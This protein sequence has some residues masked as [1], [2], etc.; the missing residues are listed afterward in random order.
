MQRV[1]RIPAPTKSKKLLV[2]TRQI[3]CL[4][5]FVLPVYKLLETPSL[6][7]QNALGDLLIPAFL[8]FFTQFIGVFALVWITEKT[9][10]GVYTLIKEK[11]GVGVAKTFYILLA[12]YFLFSSALP[13]LDLE[14]YTHAVFYDTA[15][16]RFTFA[17]FF[18][19]SG[20]VCLKNLRALGRMAELCAPVFILAFV[21]L[22]AISV[23]ESD[24][25][26]ILPWFEFPFKKIALAVKNTT[27]HFAD[28]LLLLPFLDNCDYKKGDWKKIS[29]SFWLGAVFAMIFFAVFYG[30][31]TT[32]S[33]SK[34]YAFSK[35]AQYFPALKTVGRVDLLL[36][37]LLTVI[38]SLVTALP[39]LLCC[40]CVKT[41]FGD[42]VG[43]ITAI[44]VNLALFLFLLYCNKY[45]TAIYVFFQDKLWWIFPLFNLVI[46]LL[47][48]GLLIG[49]RRKREVV[50]AK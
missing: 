29:G 2:N 15:P 32:L 22:I 41:V 38:L 46:P 14:K 18:L 16:S 24:L 27:P 48:L 17:P 25:Q 13:L 10:K 34:H 42:R 20:Y 36:T 1:Q 19:F 7:S 23:G 30:I 35:I 50:Y 6:L 49:E 47:C 11:L 43:K 33:P 37:Y 5:A 21:G 9:G 44:I 3:C 39:I 28:A 40:F 31:Y 4:V 26:S 12:V 45:Y 8:Q